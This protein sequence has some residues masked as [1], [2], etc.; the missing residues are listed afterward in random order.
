MTEPGTESV[1]YESGH[2]LA[3]IVTIVLVLL[4][5]VFIPYAGLNLAAIPLWEGVVSMVSEQ[6][7][8]A[9]ETV[10]GEASALLKGIVSVTYLG[11]NIKH[12]SAFIGMTAIITFLTWII[13]VHSNLPALGARTLKFETIWAVAWWFIPFAHLFLP[14]RVM[15][16]I[17][18]G[19]DA[20]ASGEDLEKSSP[21]LLGLWW[22]VTVPALLIGLYYF[23]IVHTIDLRAGSLNIVADLY[24]SAAVSILTIGSAIMGILVVREIDH[25]QSV[26]HAAGASA[27]G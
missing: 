25:L 7:G 9:P 22:A 10:L 16:E 5:V 12:V 23:P 8:R 3:Q 18:Q 21:A 15:L 17:W 6:Q 19:S 13:R 20:D 11:A 24:L 14:Y 27:N 2:L 1:A 26:K 4:I